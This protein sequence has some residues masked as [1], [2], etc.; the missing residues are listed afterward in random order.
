MPDENFFPIE[1]NSGNQ[2][3]FVATDIKNDKPVNVIGAA[4]MLLQLTESIV[5]R[6]LN[7]PVP[8]LK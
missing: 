4:K 1:M 2:T 8:I 6:F 5:F 3:I 7:N